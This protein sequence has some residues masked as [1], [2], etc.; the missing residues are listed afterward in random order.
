MTE[1]ADSALE[2][3][4]E[5]ASADTETI[6]QNVSNLSLDEASTSKADGG[7]MSDAAAEAPMQEEGDDQK[8]T[9]RSAELQQQGQHQRR[10]KWDKKQKNKNNH[11]QGNSGAQSF[12]AQNYK[13][14]ICRSH[15]QTGYCEY[16]GTCQFAHGIHEL[17]PRHYGLK[18]K[19]QECK[20]YHAEGYCRFGSRCKFIHDEHRIRVA[21]DEFWLV[22]PSENL[23]RVEVVENK[24]RQ[25]ELS[26]LFNTTNAEKMQPDE[27]GA[28]GHP[29]TIP[30]VVP[31][32]DPVLTATMI[33]QPARQEVQPQQRPEPALQTMQNR[34][35]GSQGKRAGGKKKNQAHTYP[36]Q[37]YQWGTVMAGD[38]N[39]PN[40]PYNPYQQFH[41]TADG[42][43]C[44]PPPPPH[45]TVMA[46]SMPGGYYAQPGPP[47]YLAPQQYPY[48]GTQMQPQYQAA[49]QY[50]AVPLNKRGPGKSPKAV[51]ASGSP[52]PGP[53][54]P[55]GA[56][57]SSFLCIRSIDFSRFFGALSVTG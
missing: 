21:E 31:V 51:A 33:Q 52:H 15:R 30:A 39:I 32:Q 49:P 50:V 25:Q 7:E 3:V 57:S 40:M 12:V 27:V 38:P 1:A 55:L 28:A 23:V 35:A 20:N 5:T 36:P 13:T 43:L 19:T 11:K 29:G 4:V 48:T 34:P 44:G 42:M 16:N 22:S 2:T 17:R 8:N 41:Y 24:T 9:Q 18:Y 6:E 53:F 14:E 45:Q 26:K 10:H 54:P 56:H 37:E 47:Q 46:P